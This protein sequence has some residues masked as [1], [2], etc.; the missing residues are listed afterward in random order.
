MKEQNRFTPYYSSSHPI[1]E[2]HTLDALETKS[3]LAKVAYLELM[4][5]RRFITE[6]LHRS[7]LG[8]IHCLHSYTASEAGGL[9]DRKET[10][11][12]HGCQSRLVDICILNEL[13]Q[14]MAIGHRPI[15]DPHTMIKFP[16]S[17]GSFDRDRR[18]EGPRDHVQCH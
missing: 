16:N 18:S 8:S 11:Y 15:T 10:G 4:R 7:I 12:T 9:P 1:T 2:S 14:E 17:L 6:S 13:K 3:I 5:V